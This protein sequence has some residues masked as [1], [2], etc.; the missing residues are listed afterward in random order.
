MITCRMSKRNEWKYMTSVISE[1]LNHIK[2]RTLKSSNIH[3]RDSAQS[4]IGKPNQLRSIVRAAP[5][6]PA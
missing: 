5:S 6:H 2:F 4:T 3:R 1:L